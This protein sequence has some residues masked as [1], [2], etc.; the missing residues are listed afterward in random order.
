M[1][2]LKAIGME[3]WC[4]ACQDQQR[5]SSLCAVAVDEVAQCGEE[6]T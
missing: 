6:N 5:R 1:R 3:D 4:T 2:G